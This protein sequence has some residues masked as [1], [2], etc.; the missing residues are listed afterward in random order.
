MGGHLFLGLRGRHF[1]VGRGRIQEE[2]AQ[3]LQRQAPR[4][5]YLLR[6]HRA[7]QHLAADPTT[8]SMSYAGRAPSC[9]PL[10]H[11][12][13]RLTTSSELHGVDVAVAS[14]ASRQRLVQLRSRGGTS[15]Q[16]ALTVCWMSSTLAAHM[17][18]SISGS[19]ASS[20]FA[21]SD[22]IA[23]AAARRPRSCPHGHTPQPSSSRIVPEPTPA[24]RPPLEAKSAIA[25]I[26]ASAAN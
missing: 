25:G 11:F 10:T 4:T 21:R 16:M 1:Q 18:S 5:A 24:I 15:W 7:A 12:W 26:V 9:A 14:A 20:S 3:L 23:A 6:H 13:I 17:A 22:A 19:A 8:L 2:T